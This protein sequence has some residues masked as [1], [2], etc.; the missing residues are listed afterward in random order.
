MNSDYA[1]VAE[2]FQNVIELK[3]IVRDWCHG[4][5]EVR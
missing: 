4:N 3:T 5:H 1:V 2:D